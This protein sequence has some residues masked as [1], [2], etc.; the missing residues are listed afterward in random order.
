M[1]GRPFCVLALF[2]AGMIFFWYTWLHP[3]EAS[4]EKEEKVQ[5]TCQVNQIQGL[6][7]KQSLV[8]CDVMLGS[9]KYC[10]RM[11]VYDSSGSTLFTDVKIGQIISLDG[12]VSSF[13]TPGNPGQF[14]EYQYYKEIGI[15]Y[16]FYAK[17]ILILKY[18]V[19]TVE[20]FLYEMR[21][22]WEQAIQNCLPEK[23]AGIMSAM[24][25][26]EKSGLSTEIKDLYKQNG[27]AHILAISGLHVSLI[28]AGLFYFL[29]KF[30]MPMKAAA[31]VTTA[32]LFLYGELTG[33]SVSTQRAVFMMV[34]VL[35]ARFL[36]KRYDRLSALALS[37]VIQLLLNPL[38][39]FQ[40]GFLLSYVTV[41]GID[42]FLKPFSQTKLIKSRIG[43]MILGSAGVFF[44][45]FPI[46]LYSYFEWNPYSVWINVLILPFVSILLVMTIV[47][48]LFSVFVLYVGKFLTGTSYFIL[49]YY[50]MLCDLTRYLPAHRMVSGQPS[51]WQIVLYYALIGTFYF[52]FRKW[53]ISGILLI[54]AISVFLFPKSHVSGLVMTNLD[55]GQGDCTCIRS[56]DVVILVDGG[57]SDV[58]EVGKYRIV[59]YLK[60]QGI[61]K[62]DYIFLTHSDDDHVNGI[63]EIIEEEDHMGL[64]I[65]KIVLPDIEKQ[66]DAYEELKNLCLQ[67][68]IHT[69]FMG[70][71]NQIK[72]G[73]L[74]LSCLHPYSSY[75][76]PSENDYSLI[77]KIGYG[78]F[79]GL[80]MGD[81][82]M[83]GENE[84][85]GLDKVNY[86]KVGHHGSKGASGENFLKKIKP[87][88]AVLSAGKN[89]RYGHPSAETLERLQTVGA[90]SY[91][92]IEDGAVTV[93]TDGEEITVD[94]YRK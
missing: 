78:N 59:P 36:G 55:V 79:T 64:Q 69:V 50:Q 61:A 67:S 94:K 73:K 4:E 72:I 14:N 84:L 58:S 42:V 85:D 66:D 31:G 46:L 52:A 45:T 22:S 29:R 51:W 39:L 43:N 80:L 90:K 63:R 6:S 54:L 13:S 49:R 2:V 57:S 82:E 88:I 76:W 3:K 81:L 91:C 75:D 65:G 35:G 25:L 93:E 83:T 37:A 53:K 24:I 41:L 89:N 28:G 60:S 32:A 34:C 21:L 23:E 20:Q 47:G 16:K 27:I 62:I 5:L 92:T 7:E 26:G 12:T 1:R 68:G 40:S 77:L 87:D 38:I 9:E 19:N 74:T 30:V 11:K 44:V 10:D 17:K 48:S 33:F 70:K 56:G 86:L 8:V 15:Q 18:N 71:E